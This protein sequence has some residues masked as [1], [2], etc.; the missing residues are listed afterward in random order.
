MLQTK[1]SGSVRPILSRVRVAIDG[2]GI[3]EW[4]Y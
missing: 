2:V 3:S 4:I 1:V